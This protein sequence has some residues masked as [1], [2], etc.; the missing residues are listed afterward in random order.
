[1]QVCSMPEY[2]VK[3]AHAEWPFC[4]GDANISHMWLENFRGSVVGT[5]GRE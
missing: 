4:A 1:M 2:K 5:S 3:D